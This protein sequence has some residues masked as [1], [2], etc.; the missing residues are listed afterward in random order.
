MCGW[1][2]GFSLSPQLSFSDSSM[3]RGETLCS[4]PL[5]HAGILSGWSLMQV[6]CLQWQSLWV[7]MFICPAV[8]RKCYFLTV[9]TEVLGWRKLACHGLACPFYDLPPWPPLARGQEAAALAVRVNP[10]WWLSS[11]HKQT[12]YYY[13]SF[14][15]FGFTKKKGG[16]EEK[17]MDK[18]KREKSLSIISS[19]PFVLYY[20]HIVMFRR[21]L[22]PFTGS[23][24]GIACRPLRHWRWAP[25]RGE[26][27]L[28]AQDGTCFA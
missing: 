7:H 23:A 27:C 6:L 17:K 24:L 13:L 16:K 19:L 20:A 22:T 9:Q 25:D 15:A 4:L 28:L 5:L 26:P 12:S 2:T 18:M 8:S 11:E 21:S 10:L 14:K 3:G 1:H